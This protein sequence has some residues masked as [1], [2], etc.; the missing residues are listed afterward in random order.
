MAP[1]HDDFIKTVLGVAKCLSFSTGKFK[2]QNSLQ[3]SLFQALSLSLK[4]ASMIENPNPFKDNSRITIII[5]VIHF[6]FSVE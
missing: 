5:K 2:I 1:R 6:R 3:F 4:I